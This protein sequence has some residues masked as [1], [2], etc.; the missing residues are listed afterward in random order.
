MEISSVETT[1]TLS[2]P[3]AGDLMMRAQAAASVAADHAEGVD[4]EARFPA[5]ALGALRDGRLLGIMIPRNLGGE[6]A[7]IS[8]VVDIIY[9]LAQSC[10]AT[11]M[12]YAMHQVQIACI[13]RHMQ[14]SR[15]LEQLLRRL[16]ADQLLLAS[17]TTEG[18]S[19]GDI[20]SNEASLQFTLGR[21]DLERRSNVISYGAHADGILATARRSLEGVTS[22]QVLV[23]FMKGD[24]QL[25]RVQDWHVLGMRGT[26]S[27]GYI[28]KATGTMEQVLPEPYSVIHAQTMVP[29]AH[30]LWG[31]VWAG[32]AAEAV[33][34]AQS[35]NQRMIRRDNGQ[36]PLGSR[37]FMNAFAAMQSLRSMLQTALRRYERDMKDSMALSSVDFQHMITLAKVEMSELAVTA[38]LNAFRSCGLS[39]Y[40]TDGEF[41]IAR[42]LRDVLSSPVMINNERI[43]SNLVN[44]A[45]KA[46][47]PESVSGSS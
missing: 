9:R 5:E 35:F 38:V 31:A 21:I 23:V 27:D 22:D 19:G 8:R 43:M 14:S 30:L 17:A 18:Q 13:V 11:A 46:S 34:R 45:L 33:G 16:C 42:N 29:F 12:I 25:T 41:S 10:A 26:C 3:V 7:G 4:R 44:S 15:F 47:L 40:R 32:I 20:R 24:Y 39:G 36:L 1:S 28:L 2:T 37:H 6:E